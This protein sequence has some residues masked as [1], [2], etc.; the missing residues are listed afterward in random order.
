MEAHE[1]TIIVPLP[2]E[3][4]SLI[5]NNVVSHCETMS[6]IANK[7]ERFAFIGACKGVDHEALL[8]L[9]RVAVEDLGVIEGIQGD[10]ASEILAG[11]VEDLVSYKLD[12]MFT[13]NRVCYFYP[14]VIR[15]SGTEYDGYYIGAATAGFF[16]TDGRISSLPL[17]NK[18]LW[19]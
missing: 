12:E 8:G 6:T 13:S 15:V 18:T 17:T 5:F 9:K 2:T 4:K 10:E 3:H 14:D 1:G 7:K 19:I 11:Q 16:C